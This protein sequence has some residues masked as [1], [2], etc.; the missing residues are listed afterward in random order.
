MKKK[1]AM[2]SLKANFDDSSIPAKAIT[3]KT[4]L[5]AVRQLR[6]ETRRWTLG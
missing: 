1:N 5:A 3:E 4:K 2:P 6:C